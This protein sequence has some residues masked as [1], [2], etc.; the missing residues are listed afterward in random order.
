LSLG[1]RIREA[2]GTLTQRELADLLGVDPITVSRWERGT[3]E[4]SGRRIR[5]IAEA[6]GRKAEWFYLDEPEAAVA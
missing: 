5:K 4:P 6:T 3:V 1:D 2:R